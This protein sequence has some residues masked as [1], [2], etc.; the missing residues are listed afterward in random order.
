MAEAAHQPLN[1]AKPPLKRPLFAKPSWA[2]VNDLGHPADFFRRSDQSYVNVAAESERKRQKKV[3]RK[4]REEARESEFAEPAK[5]RQRSSSESDSDADSDGFGNREGILLESDE[6]QVDPKIMVSKYE[7]TEDSKTSFKAKHMPTSLSKTYETAITAK[8]CEKD[9]QLSSSIVIELDDE[10]SAPEAYQDEVVEVT[11]VKQPEPLDE[12]DDFP[13]SDD[14][15]AE[16]ARQ[17]REKARRKRLE[18]DILNPAQDSLPTGSQFDHFSQFTSAHEPSALPDPP[19][20]VVSILITSEIPN[21]EALVVNRKLSQRLKDVRLCW[22]QR[23]GFSE[24]MTDTVLL[25]WR[26]NR[27][28]DVATCKSLGI[29]VSPDGNIVLQ[30]QRD[31]F[32]EEEKRI[33]MEAMTEERFDEQ[34]RLKRLGQTQEDQSGS[35]VQEEEPPQLEKKERELRIVLKA[36]GFTDFKLSVQPV[37]VFFVPRCRLWVSD[38]PLFQTTR[39]SRI[40]NVFKMEKRLENDREVFLSFDGERLAPENQVESTELDDM[41]YIDVYIK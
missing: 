6:K 18:T 13:P 21:T 17:A 26:G 14:E 1:G 12:D 40:V 27:L 11:S 16:L 32:G 23:Q 30:N 4:Q 7:N 37:G 22:C 24:E 20:S 38:N 31:I 34:Q 29:G 8:R 2:Q 41:D 5:K 35:A 3:A 33:H 28:F 36:K 15:F 9:K 25:T 39:V 19:D 10:D